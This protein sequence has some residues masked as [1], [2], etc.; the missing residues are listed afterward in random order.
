MIVQ[1]GSSASGAPLAWTTS[2]VRRVIDRR[3]ELECRVEMELAP[4]APRWAT[5]SVSTPVARPRVAT[6][7][8]SGRRRPS[9][10]GVDLGVVAGGDGLGERPSARVVAGLT[11]AASASGRSRHRRRPDPG[12]LHAVLGEGAGLVGADD[13]RRAQRLDR[14][15]PLD[16]RAPPG[17]HPHADREGKR[18]RRQQPLGDV[19]DQETDREHGRVGER[20]PAASVPSGRKARPTATATPAISQATRRTS[21]SSGLSS[22]TRSESAAMRPSS[23]RMPVAKT[24]ASASPP[25]Q[26]V[27]LNT[28]SRASRNPTSISVSSAERNTGSDSPVNAAVSSSTDPASRRASAETRSPS[29]MSNTSPGTRTRAS[30]RRRW[31]SRRTVA[32]AGK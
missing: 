5:R 32:W 12:D 20:Q 13:R 25:V 24:T 11:G 31:P 4:P 26:A 21:R 23:V 6:R 28:R 1:R 30:T 27:P 3:H 29:A 8:R 18:D 9:V 10:G 2:A 15:E 14:A 16:E 19:G 22:P 7:S 17:Q